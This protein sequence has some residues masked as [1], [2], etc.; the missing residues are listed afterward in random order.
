MAK[1]APLQDNFLG[2]EWSANFQGRIK[3]P[4][5]DSAMQSM[6]NCLPIEEGAAPRRAGFRFAQL[7]RQGMLGRV[8]SFDW[9]QASPYVMEFTPGIMRLFSGPNLVMNPD[10]RNVVS[11]ST[12]TPAVITIDSAS[13]WASLDQVAF[14]FV[15]LSPTAQCNQLQNRTFFITVINGTQFSIADDFGVPINGAALNWGPGVVLQ[16]S[17][18]LNFTTPWL[19]ADIQTLRSVQSGTQTLLLSGTQPPWQLSALTNASTI[20]S[21]SQFATFNFVA[22][23]FLDGPYLDPTNG[24]E[25][26]VV[27]GGGT[28]VINVSGVFTAWSSTAAYAAGDVVTYAGA[29][30]IALATNFDAAPNVSPSLWQLTTSGSGFNP[31]V[32]ALSTDTGRSIR[33]WQ[34]PLDYSP[35][36][37]YTA[38]QVVTYPIGQPAGTAAYYQAI[39]T[40]PAGTQPDISPTYWAPVSGAGVAA[41]TWGII[42]AV[43]PPNIVTVTL[44]STVLLY[45]SNPIVLFQMGAFSGTTGYP[46]AGC[47][48]QGRL[49]L[50]GANI[51]SQ[52]RVYG[53]VSNNLSSFSP[54]SPDGTVAD[55]NG[56]SAKFDSGT[57]NPIYW[58][59][60]D[61]QGILCG[62][63]EG[64][65]LIHASQL[66]DPITPTS[67]QAH[68]QTKYGCANIEPK[69]T[70]LT[71]A[72]VHRYK[73]KLLEFFAD[74]FSGKYTAPNLTETGKHLTV[75][76]IS[77]IAYQQELAPV[78]WLRMANGTL[79]GCTYKRTSLFSSEPA[80]FVGWHHHVLG[81]ARTVQ[82]ITV[83]PSPDGA[84][85]SLCML[86]QDP[87]TGICHI[88]FSAKLF[89]IGDTIYSA[90]QLDDA[91]T[92]TQAVG[93]SLNVTFYGYTYLNGKTVTAWVG[94]LDCGD[95]VVSNGSITVPYGAAGG[96]FTAAYLQGI[97]GQSFGGLATP[98]T[99]VS[100]VLP[101]P[102]TTPQTIL[103][104]IPNPAF[105]PVDTSPGTAL[106][107]WS[108]QTLF[109][110]TNSSAAAAIHTYSL[111]NGS[112]LTGSPLQTIT[113]SS[114][115]FAGSALGPDGNIYVSGADSQAQGP[116]FKISQALALLGTFGSNSSSGGNTPNG[117]APGPLAAVTAN[118]TTFVVSANASGLATN[119]GVTNGN[120]MQW[121]APAP[122][123]TFNGA[124]SVLLTPGQSG[125]QTGT[126]FAVS[127][128][129]N[130]IYELNYISLQEIII[131]ASAGTYA[132]GYAT[133]SSSTA[134]VVGNK[135]Q[136]QGC[137]YTCLV[138]NT[139]VAP[140]S[141]LGTDW[142]IIN[143]PYISFSTIG[144]VT[145]AQL[146]PIGVDFPTGAGDV[147]YDHSDGNIIVFA[148]VGILPNDTHTHQYVFKMNSVTGARMWKLNLST[149]TGGANVSTGAFVQS[150][151][152]QGVLSMMAATGGLTLAINTA[153]GT[154]SSYT[155]ANVAMGA[156]FSSDVSGVLTGA[157]VYTKTSTSPQPI[158]ATPAALSNVWAQLQAGS[159]FYGAT[160]T[161]TNLSI[162]AVIGFTFT[163]TG[164]CLPP[165]MPQET[166]SVSG[167]ALVKKRRFAQYGIKLV[168]AQGVSIGTDLNTQFPVAFEQQ[169]GTLLPITSLF[170]GTHWDT[171]NDDSS[172][173]SALS[174]SVTRPYPCT[175]TAIGGFITTQ[176]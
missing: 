5:Y 167:P 59:Q 171:L 42:T 137:A 165:E 72:V 91:C 117:I 56:I 24:A 16:V 115:G 58:L 21:S 85:D 113:G 23:Q 8:I 50:T 142:Q 140:T 33:I 84:L 111:G 145:A 64:E 101:P 44:Q 11:I 73:R 116:L 17:K 93:N 146:D 108:T 66:N 37:G 159:F 27:S 172:F 81:S 143:N 87:V 55:S 135:I 70:G 9:A 123:A 47:Y 153:T 166:G 12:A 162:P 74:T 100:T 106:V 94:G 151:I 67:I 1:A 53:S 157:V 134:Y 46:T 124:Q 163:T 35:S 13:P 65:W 105:G 141:S 99:Q 96:L 152:T 150:Q 79:S 173:N 22:A 19:A 136:Y 82:S 130:S 110:L 156:Q 63:Q 39:I 52:N 78:I 103:G 34:Q 31:N 54:T 40:V 164:L 15:A 43:S 131:G 10:V 114:D 49:W 89:D 83:G 36:G 25:L 90:W 38:G 112:N 149:V 98:L 119:F 3:H 104:F 161:T 41:W 148:Y 77:E 30:Y 174:W 169:P 122:G 45:P 158:N 139:N 170:T 107:N 20:P 62:T 61:A 60:P 4:K 109:A 168:N 144:Q 2:G 32:G 80:V 133:W 125:G 129:N 176:D 154:Y 128:N 155:A 118:G 7:T 51:S 160:V 14:Q 126:V 71:L 127:N 18:V 138:N 121:A 86:T 57:V 97:Q 48:H 175:V 147:V 88:E 76:G 26:T 28:A 102:N 92:P 132:A 29:D 120:T 68:R 75:S 95:Y 6:L 69:R